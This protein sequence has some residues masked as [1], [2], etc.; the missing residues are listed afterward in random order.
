M[1]K[2]EMDELIE[3]LKR[4]IAFFQAQAKRRGWNDE[5]VEAQINKYLE[6]I[7]MLVELKKK[8]D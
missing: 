4:E 6:D 1:T 8:L 2:Q 5:I 7:Q 3:E